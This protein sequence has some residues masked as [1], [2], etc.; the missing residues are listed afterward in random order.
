M[1]CEHRVGDMGSNINFD[2]T[3]PH[4]AEKSLVPHV[5]TVSAT[6]G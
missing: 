1:S 6:Y 2:G 5:T 4:E 3:V